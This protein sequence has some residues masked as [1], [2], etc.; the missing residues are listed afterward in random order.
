MINLDMKYLDIKINVI[1]WRAPPPGA[2]EAPT[3]ATLCHGHELVEDME[4][5][6]RG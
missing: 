6:I 1:P 4:A 5:K 3:A 2:S